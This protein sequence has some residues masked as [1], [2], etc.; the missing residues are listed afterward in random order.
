MLDE[1]I[2]RAMLIY[3]TYACFFFVPGNVKINNYQDELHEQMLCQG[4]WLALAAL[5]PHPIL[6]EPLEHAI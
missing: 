5:D 1:T 3:I 6:Q 4:G 2:L